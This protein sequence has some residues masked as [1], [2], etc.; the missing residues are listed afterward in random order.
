MESLIPKLSRVKRYVAV[1]LVSNHYKPRIEFFRQTAVHQFQFLDS[2]SI[3]LN[4]Y[5]PISSKEGE[6]NGSQNLVTHRKTSLNCCQRF[7]N[8]LFTILFSVRSIFL[9][10]YYS[11]DRVLSFFIICYTHAIQ[12]NLV[13]H[14]CGSVMSSDT[15]M[16]FSFR[17]YSKPPGETKSSIANPAISKKKTRGCGKQ[18][19]SLRNNP[20]NFVGYL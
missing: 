17:V 18:S 11:S 1:V 15:N 19:K 3:A 14:F 7:L 16:N 8:R 13:L 9:D 4:C 10:K 2:C 5:L 12:N 6:L 20:V